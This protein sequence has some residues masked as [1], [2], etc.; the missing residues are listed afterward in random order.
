MEC[1]PRVTLTGGPISPPSS[2][3]LTGQTLWAA[4]AFSSAFVTLPTV[5]EPSSPRVKGTVKVAVG[6]PGSG[7][8]ETWKATL[9]PLAGT[10]LRFM[11]SSREVGTRPWL[12]GEGRS[13]REPGLR[14]VGM[15]ESRFGAQA[16]HV[17]G[18][19]IQAVHRELQAGCRESRVKVIA[20]G[21]R[22]ST[23][24]RRC[25]MV[26]AFLGLGWAG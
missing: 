7:S 4:I 22:L 19:V 6:S 24:A 11:A 14:R 13:A 12:A 2:S 10:L 20:L 15:V 3:P 16:R 9:A 18:L 25:G 5:I 21:L 26:V 17:D 8:P 23:S 1:P